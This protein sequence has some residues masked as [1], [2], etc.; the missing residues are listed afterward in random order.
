[1]K[2]NNILIA[3]PEIAAK[4]HQLLLIVNVGNNQHFWLD[5]ILIRVI[6]IFYLNLITS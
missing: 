5:K 2:T 4:H 6:N 1:M 3:L